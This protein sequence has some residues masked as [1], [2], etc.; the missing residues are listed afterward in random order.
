MAARM[1]FNAKLYL[2]AAFMGEHYGL[3]AGLLLAVLGAVLAL[4]VL[5]AWRAR[6]APGSRLE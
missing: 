1:N 6:A 3:P 4:L 2:Q 5:H